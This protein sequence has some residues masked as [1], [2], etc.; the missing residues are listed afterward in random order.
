MR[1]TSIDTAD[2][3]FVAVALAVDAALLS[4]ADAEAIESSCEGIGSDTQPRSSLS[5][6]EETGNTITTREYRFLGFA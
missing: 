1:N 5:G 2:A 3:A 6:S 4:D